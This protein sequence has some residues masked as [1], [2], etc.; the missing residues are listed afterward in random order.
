M[1]DAEKSYRQVTTRKAAA[2]PDT[3][4]V[5]CPALTIAYH[6]D[7]TRIGEQYH[8]IGLKAGATIGVSRLEPQ[9][10]DSSGRFRALE[11]SFLSRSPIT[12]AHPSNTGWTVERP[13]DGMSVSIDG[14]TVEGQGAFQSASLER[15]VVLEIAERVVLVLHWSTIHAE[16]T[17]DFSM[18]G[19]NDAMVRLRT[20]IARVAPHD[21][22]VLIR[23]ETGTGKELVAQAIHSAGKRADHALVSVNMAAIPPTTATSQL[24]G[25]VKGAF[26]GATE[27]H[28][29]YF[30][31]ANRGTLFLDEVGETPPE[32][33]AMLLRAVENGEVQ[34]VGGRRP[35]RVDVRFVAATD[36]DLEDR[37]DD[38]RFSSPLL[39]RLGGYQITIPPLRERRDDIGLLF[40]HFLLQELAQVGGA[41][42]LA[43]QATAPHLWL[44]SNL[45]ARLVTY[46][47]PGNVRQLRNLAQQ[48]AIRHG[49]DPVVQLSGL[50][51]DLIDASEPQAA[52]VSGEG[53]KPSD[54]TEEELLGALRANQWRLRATAKHFGI[55]K[56]SLY[57]MIDR[58]PQIRKAGDLTK[59]ELTTALAEMG[60]DLDAMVERLEV[61]KRGIQL[62]MKA[63][64]VG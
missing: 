18:V 31:R 33:Q 1:S 5:R 16:T 2:A 27:D 40:V 25:H 45:V 10:S 59:A 42:K 37:V 23:G 20:D 29:G 41:D 57:A 47:W 48:I 61:S 46:H 62:Q 43:R 36:A 32:I 28:S 49:A 54:I 6:P 19:H 3:G 11:D 38:E 52:I 8:L 14:V 58:C 35:S 56:T 50:M 7:I 63:L 21:V 13:G 30:G 24:F 15:G 26:T 60:G 44:P 4:V 55:S 17:P 12:I 9:F 34:P 51:D 53:R 39:H 64:G 22:P